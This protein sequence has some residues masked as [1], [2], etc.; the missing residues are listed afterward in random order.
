MS[1]VNLSLV[2]IH[3][4]A[5]EYADD[6][7]YLQHLINVAEEKIVTDTNR[8]L[9][10]LLTLSADGKS[11]PLQLQQACLLC[12]GHWYNQRESVSVASMS[13]VPMGYD[14]LVKPFRKLV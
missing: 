5:D 6:D 13:S 8:T 11:L 2:K 12:V 9:E 4:R 3:V 14:S 10:D 7:I 1:I